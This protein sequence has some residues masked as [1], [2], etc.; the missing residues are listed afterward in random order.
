[1]HTIL[2]I[3]Q[4]LDMTAEEA[5]EKLQYMEFEIETVESE[6][7]DDLCDLLIDID[8][9]PDVVEV[10]RKKNL[11]KRERATKAA[12]KAAAKRKAVAAKKKVAES[13]KETAAQN[14]DVGENDPEASAAND[15]EPAVIIGSAMEHD[16][17]TVEVARADGTHLDLDK[18]ALDGYV[19]EGA[20]IGAGGMGTV[21]KCK[22]KIDRRVF[23]LKCLHLRF[24]ANEEWCHQFIREA[25]TTQ[26]QLSECRE[27][28]SVFHVGEKD[29]EIEGTVHRVLFFV[30]D[31][32]HGPD[33]KNPYTLQ[34]FIDEQF[35]CEGYEA[36]LSGYLLGIA[37]ACAF[38]HGRGVLH[39]DIKPQNVLITKNH[40]VRLID[41]GLVKALGG[42]ERVTTLLESVDS[43]DT[44]NSMPS[45]SALDVAAKA[46]TRRYIA[47]EGSKDRRSDIYSFCCMAYYAF[48][49]K[50]RMIGSPKVHEIS[51]RADKFWEEITLRG[52][53]VEPEE[54][55]S[56]FQEIVDLIERGSNDESMSSSRASASP[57]RDRGSVCSESTTGTSANSSTHSVTNRSGSDTR[58]ELIESPRRVLE[59]MD[60]NGEIYKKVFLLTG[61]WLV[62]G[63]ERRGRDNDIDVTLRVL[64]YDERNKFSEN[65]ERNLKI[66]RRAFRILVRPGGG[67]GIERLSKPSMTQDS[68]K[69][70]E[71][72]RGLA[73]AQLSTS[74]LAFARG[75]LY[76]LPLYDLPYG[77]V[78]ALPRYFMID[79]GS[80][81]MCLRGRQGFGSMPAPLL[82]E[83]LENAT[84][85]SYIWLPRDGSA[86]SVGFRGD[87]FIRFR[88]PDRHKRS[89]KGIEES[90]GPKEI[91]LT[92]ARKDFWIGPVSD[93]PVYV[94]DVYV[95][96][97][98]SEVI[99][100]PCTITVGSQLLRFDEAHDDHFKWI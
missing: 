45:L 35:G 92:Y 61:K 3:A 76:D 100:A 73:Y 8:D 31:F 81:A 95:P 94:N 57:G 16:V 96:R 72:D 89:H 49:R 98:Q 22:R 75:Q 99:D 51:P 83:R 25:T 65:R 36:R 56:S 91:A 88:E 84:N 15:S 4:H 43:T 13:T 38:A 7:T 23:A 82:V 33:G 41:F 67:L 27:I 71:I 62:F 53:H 93:L 9:D 50:Y 90:S 21:W 54:R 18:V 66:P 64:P 29:F 87:S 6:I 52:L 74:D 86:A 2:S 24:A 26:T 48:T 11:A 10:T 44:M 80:G 42:D 60:S 40:E 20:P 78:V 85:H 32:V 19:I 37:K 30:M 70:M 17:P 68:L 59:V 46:G 12:R 28:V 14:R 63:R 34:Q 55:W 97:G 5:L 47:P 79:I 1:M 58:S 69:L 77:H 39:R